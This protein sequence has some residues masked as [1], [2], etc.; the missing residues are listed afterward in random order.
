MNVENE[1][2]TLKEWKEVEASSF[3]RDGSLKL[4]LAEIN[5]NSHNNNN[6]ENNNNNFQSSSSVIYLLIPL[7][8]PEV[9]LDFKLPKQTV[10]FMNGL[11]EKMSNS[12]RKLIIEKTLPNISD[13][14]SIWYSTLHQ[15]NKQPHQ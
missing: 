10:Q 5:Q 13:C 9:S 8:Y 14:L 7:R 3:E 11:E 12:F 1:L 4:T 6:H 15:W 2:K